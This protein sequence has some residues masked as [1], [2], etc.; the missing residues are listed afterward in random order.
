MAQKKV[1]VQETNTDLSL[2]RL[3]FFWEKKQKTILTVVVV[4]TALAAGWF[5]YRN[6]IMKPNEKKAAD[7]IGQ[8]QQFFA[9]DSLN[10]A[11]NGA[12][13]SRGFLYVIKNYGGTP[14]GN[15]AKYYAGVSYLRLGDINNAVKYLKS[16]ST[17]AKQIQMVAY[18]ALGDA[19][20]EQKKIT[21]AVDAYKKAAATFEEDQV[22]ASE[23]LFRAAALN[24]VNNRNK[25][26]VELYK[27][28]K[29]KF[30]LTTRGKEA[31][32]YI[33]RLSIEPNELK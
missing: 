14:S 33:Y 16:F 27:E 5:G 9:M 18:G 12:G 30:P 19:Y 10:L 26:A 8:A 13:T 20:S 6:Y 11:L 32:K 31:D 23:Y 2:D 22:L 7:A 21:E 29:E 1:K 25:E 28:M 3:M 4:V 17:D 15:L 24:E